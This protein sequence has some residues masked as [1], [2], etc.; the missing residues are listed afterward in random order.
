MES[1]NKKPLPCHL[2]RSKV[3]LVTNSKQPTISHIQ[4]HLMSRR[5]LLVTTP[6]RSHREGGRPGPFTAEREAYYSTPVRRRRYVRGSHRV[7][8]NHNKKPL[9]CYL[10]RFKV[11]LVTNPK[12]PNISHT[13]KNLMSRRKLPVTT[14][15]RP[16]REG[17]RS[18]PCTAE[19]E[20]YHST[21]IRGRRYV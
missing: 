7:E 17:G 16:H 13:Q 10:K 9:P 1:N 2:K 4:K 12:Q 21:P 18:G 3:P 5:K 11:P 8:S 6:L 15:L 20:A 14:P 19:R